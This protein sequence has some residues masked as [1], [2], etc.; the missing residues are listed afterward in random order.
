MARRMSLPQLER[1]I[2]NTAVHNLTGKKL[3]FYEA[4]ALGKGLNFIPIVKSSPQRAIQSIQEGVRQLRRRVNLAY[5][6][7]A[8]G[9]FPTEDKDPSLRVPNPAFE[10]PSAAPHP[11][12]T[13]LNRCES[14]LL[15]DNNKKTLYSAAQLPKHTNMCRKQ[16]KALKGLRDR[17]DI[18]IKPCDKN[19]GI[20]VVTRDWYMGEALRQ[21][22]DRH[23][24]DVVTQ[25]WP[26]V[27][28]GL[29]S[30]LLAILYTS[31]TAVK[32][33]ISSNIHTHKPAFF[34][35]IIK[36]HKPVVVG[37]P[38]VSSVE[39]LTTPASKYLDA[40]L[41]PFLV[42]IPT[43]LKDSTNLV[44]HMQS[45]VC[46]PNSALI[47]HDIVSLYPSIPLDE[48][49]QAAAT[50]IKAHFSDSEA[51][52]LISLL[53]FVLHNN[54]FY[55]NDTLY[56]QIQGTA[57]G[58]SV[59][60]A[61]ACIFVH[62]L[63]ERMRSEHPALYNQFAYYK[64]YIDDSLGI[65]TGSQ[66][67]FTEYITHFNNLCPSIKLTYTFS[68]QSVD[69]LDVKIHKGPAFEATH[70]LDTRLFEKP[71]NKY[72]Y[73]A[74]TSGHT[75][76]TKKG[77]IRGECIRFCR[78]SSQPSYYKQALAAFRKRLN[79][80]GYGNALIS[81]VFATVAY[82]D[83]HKFIQSVITPKQQGSE[84]SFIPLKLEYTGIMSRIH[85]QQCINITPEG[86]DEELTSER[87]Y[88]AIFPSTPR[89]SWHL[90][91]NISSIVTSTKHV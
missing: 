31:P 74:A 28:T 71:L 63:E 17:K 33:F 29:I 15:S 52:F 3:S 6:F 64:R 5:F 34:Y 61:F 27:A 13:F 88:K 23:V 50:F 70:I 12:S 37:R 18:V 8:M 82:S 43:Y 2:Q 14:R 26:E 21:L 73:V 54:Y 90:P 11:Y 78:L 77:F 42:Q 49:L 19:L 83:R 4:K 16:W 80:R 30:K 7:R 48:G 32:K 87:F 76:S 75:L 39:Y 67:E 10:A 66:A 22:S 56:H 60:V 86:E 35:L 68:Y 58:T 85:A 38:I 84:D 89:V 65:W 24:Y 44:H 46:P 72:L 41:Q 62:S 53:E 55:F 79:A 9:M 59:A 57:M 91:R 25:D 51:D 20:A 45:F 1:R 47:S 40:K 69:F 36:V 81:E